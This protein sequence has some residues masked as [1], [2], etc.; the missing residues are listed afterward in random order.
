MRLVFRRST[1]MCRKRTKLRSRKCYENAYVDAKTTLTIAT[2]IEPSP[3]GESRFLATCPPASRPPYVPN[4]CSHAINA[5]VKPVSRSSAILR[6]ATFLA[7]PWRPCQPPR[8]F[9][10]PRENLAASASVSTDH[11]KSSYLPP[12]AA[13]F[14]NAFR[15][16]IPGYSLETGCSRFR[17]QSD[18]V[19]SR[20]ASFRIRV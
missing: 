14:V 12:N 2:G 7:T 6:Y 15:E 1:K 5:T 8:F 4:A 19:C 11:R 18:A 16:N 10:I 3:D 17:F 13:V 20:Y 9:G